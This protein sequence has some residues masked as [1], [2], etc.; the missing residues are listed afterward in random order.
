[1]VGYMIITGFTVVLL[2]SL[3]KISSSFSK[4]TK[5]TASNI[6]KWSEKLV[7]NAN[8]I[9]LGAGKTS[10]AALQETKNQTMRSLTS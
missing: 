1:M 7:A 6:F 4:F 2:W 5:D 8:L 9:P 3:I 10:L